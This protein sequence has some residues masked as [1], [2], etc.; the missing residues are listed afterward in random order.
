[1]KSFK[2]HSKA[3]PPPS[4]VPIFVAGSSSSTLAVR[5]CQPASTN[6]YGLEQPL[7][8]MPSSSL[9]SYPV[10]PSSVS[11]FQSVYGNSVAAPP[12][13]VSLNPQY[14]MQSVETVLVRSTVL[15]VT[16]IDKVSR[17]HQGTGQSVE[18]SY[19]NDSGTVIQ[20]FSEALKG[21]QLPKLEL[22][23]FSGDPL[24]FQQW[25]ASFENIIEDATTEPARRLH[26]L[27]QYTAG[28]A[29]SPK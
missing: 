6:V 13:S 10:V 21:N 14:P 5:S 23:V 9:S 26:Y 15:V 29:R 25:L 28:N 24:D 4:Q 8:S 18:V 27:M 2:V 1:M 17:Q 19:C 22:S 3:Q 12:A 11:N 7:F 16:G 20:A